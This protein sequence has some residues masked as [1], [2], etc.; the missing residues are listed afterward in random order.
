METRLYSPVSIVR[1][2]AMR[3]GSPYAPLRDL[4]AANLTLGPGSFAGCLASEA[5]SC[6]DKHFRPAAPK[7]TQPPRDWVPVL[8]RT[9]L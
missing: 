2:P 3:P 6:C 8:R 7:N 1:P 9:C 4:V 5:T